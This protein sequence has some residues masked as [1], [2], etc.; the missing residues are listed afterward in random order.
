M[1]NPTLAQL[2]KIIEKRYPKSLASDWD[3]VGLIVGKQKNIIAKILLTVDITLEVVNE[4][5][6]NKFDLIISHHPLILEPEEVEDV[7]KYKEKIKDLMNQNKLSLYVAHT[8]ADAADGGVNDSFIKLFNVKNVRTFGPQ[9]I[10]RFG[11][12]EKPEKI[13]DIIKKLKN[14][15]PNN[16]NA[17][18]I[19]DNTDRDINSVAV[20]GGSG[21]FL[22]E[23]VRALKVDLFITADLKHHSVLDNKELGGPVLI[24]VSHWA[25]ERIWLDDF[26]NQ[27]KDDFKMS[28]LEAEI[29]ISTKITDPWDLSIGFNS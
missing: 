20:C 8:N 16:K 14:T 23:Q 11:E 9:N 7:R 5:L 19:S 12:F 25:S 26:S 18:L 6:E 4:A 21:S 29:F 3:S 22:L 27:L 13:E 24:N 28:N 17:I 10:G 2:A 1:T 15:I